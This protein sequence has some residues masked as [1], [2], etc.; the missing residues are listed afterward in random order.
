MEIIEDR[1]KKKPTIIPSQL[2]LEAWHEIIGQQT[3]ADAILDRLVHRAH[4]INLKGELMRKTKKKN[5]IK[6]ESILSTWF[7]MLTFFL[8]KWFTLT[9]STILSALSKL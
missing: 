9:G 7:A 6:M 5:L 1:H 3:I 2:P 8:C 4:R